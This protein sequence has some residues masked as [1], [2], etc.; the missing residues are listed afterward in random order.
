MGSYGCSASHRE[1]FCWSDL[2]PK[3]QKENAVTEGVQILP[4]AILACFGLCLGFEINRRHKKLRTVFNTFDKNECKLADAM[5]A[6][7]HRSELRPF[8]PQ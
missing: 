1:N 3:H 7:I 8:V 2:K 4:L 6:M 5:E